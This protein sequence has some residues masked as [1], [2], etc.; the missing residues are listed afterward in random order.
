ML[1]QAFGAIDLQKRALDASWLRQDVLA[2][3]IANINTP[4]YKRKDVTFDAMLEDFLSGARTQL[5][6]THSRHIPSASHDG[7]QVIS[8]D[9]TS[10]R[11]DGNNVNIDTEMAEIAKNSI[12]YNAMTTD[13]NNQIR[14]L[15][16]AIRVGR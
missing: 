1:N 16:A 9:H 5:T 10:L 2:E 12:K 4:G 13:V 8:D 15:K 3:N 7:I 6:T 11:I 14:R